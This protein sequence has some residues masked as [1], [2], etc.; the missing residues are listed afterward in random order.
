MKT[1]I[2]HLAT[3]LYDKGIFP[4]LMDKIRDWAWNEE[5]Y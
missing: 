2:Y 4:W 1:K 3:R 5:L